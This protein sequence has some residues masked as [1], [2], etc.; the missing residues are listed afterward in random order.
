[1]RIA[2]EEVFGPVLAIIPYGDEF[3]ARARNGKVGDR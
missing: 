2:R 3:G 1:M